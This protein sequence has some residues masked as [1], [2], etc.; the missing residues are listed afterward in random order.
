LF[1]FFEY[2]KHKIP[3]NIPTKEYKLPNQETGKLTREAKNNIP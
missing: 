1:W 3:E 2:R